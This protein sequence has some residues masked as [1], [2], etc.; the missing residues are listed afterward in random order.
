MYPKLKKLTHSQGPAGR[1]GWHWNRHALV[2]QVTVSVSHPV[3]LSLD[4]PHPPVDIC[5]EYSHRCLTIYP[6]LCPCIYSHL[7]HIIYSHLCLVLKHSRHRDLCLLTTTP[8]GLC[9]SASQILTVPK[10]HWP[11]RPHIMNVPLSVLSSPMSRWVVKKLLW[12]FEFYW[13]CEGTLDSS[14]YYYSVGCLSEATLMF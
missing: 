2:C 6:H 1:S 8:T 9:G 11:G 4:C 3:V 13:L 5:P 10:Q 12:L 7:Y 14:H